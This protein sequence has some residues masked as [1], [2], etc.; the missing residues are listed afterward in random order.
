MQACLRTLLTVASCVLVGSGL[1]V[2]AEAARI[3]VDQGATGAGDG[4]SWADAFTKLQDALAAANAGDEI[5]VAAGV[6]YPDEGG[7]QTDDDRSATF[8]LLDDVAIFGGFAG[9]ETTL[10]Q[11]DPSSNVTVLSGDID[12]DDTTDP[13]GVVTTTNDIS[14]ANSFH[15]VTGSGTSG[16]AV[17]DGFTI[18]A[19]L[20]NGSVAPC[21]EICGGGLFNESGS[22][23]LSN[24]VFSGNFAQN[25]GGGMLNSGGST[26]TLTRVTF[27]GN[28]AGQGG[29]VANLGSSPQFTDAEFLGNVAQIGSGGNGAGMFNLNGSAPVL[30]RVLF[31]GNSALVNGG[32]M[33][34]QSSSSAMLR[35]GIFVGNSAAFGGG[36][37]NLSGSDSQLVNVVFSGNVA[38]GIGGGIGGGMLNNNSSPTLTNVTFSG[39]VAAGSIQ[40]GGGMNN[41]TGSNPVLVNVILWANSATTGAQILNTG[42]STPQIS[43]SDVEGSGGS[44]AGWDASLGTDVGGNIDADPLFVD[45]DGADDVIGTPDDNLRPR[46]GSPAN[47][48]GNNNASGLTGVTTDLDRKP[49]FTDDPSVGDT[50]QGTPP[51]VDMGAYEA[52]A[53]LVGAPASS[54]WGVGF[55]LLALIAAARYRARRSFV[56]GP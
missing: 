9:G 49:R 44:G 50:G 38:T 3:F 39:N 7:G 27:S 48:A 2:P 19:G 16:S 14:G 4:S 33:F 37:Y 52:L 6:Y 22:P 24:L 8:Q 12:Q 11:R 30:T 32:G 10:A 5:W 25:A 29:G 35:D 20:A 54:P 36:L 46:L 1:A 18:T 56:A 51:I 31:S 23:T 21:Q 15:V 17:L 40:Q 53:S 13:N 55:L 41:G 28:R 34:N 43:F 47:D 42:G 26:P 45:P